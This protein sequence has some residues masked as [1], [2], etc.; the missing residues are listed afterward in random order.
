MLIASTTEFYHNTFLNRFNDVLQG[1]DGFYLHSLEPLSTEQLTDTI[2]RLC[3][4]EKRFHRSLAPTYGCIIRTWAKRPQG[5]PLSISDPDD[6]AAAGVDL[7]DECD[8]VLVGIRSVEE[9][10]LLTYTPSTES[11]DSLLLGRHCW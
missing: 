1:Q 9:Y 5:D 3:N 11:Y 6:R 4:T 2:E 8:A 10:T 7:E